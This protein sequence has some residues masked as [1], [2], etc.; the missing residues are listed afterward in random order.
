MSLP[1][2]IDDPA[3]HL[4]E[5]YGGDPANLDV[6][7]MR[8]LVTEAD[9]LA[10]AL[11]YL[12]HH[13]S[14]EQTGNAVTL[15]AVH[16][17]WARQARDLITRRAFRRAYVAPRELGK[18]TWHF[19]AVP[20]WAAAH[21][22]ATFVA[23][24]ADAGRLA[25]THL[26]TFLTELR[27]NERLRQDYPDLCTPL[28]LRRGITEADRVDLYRAKS[29]FIFAARGMEAQA[30]GLK[31]GNHRPDLLILDDIE[32]AEEV[33]SAATVA[34]R[35]ATLQDTVL[36]L[37]DKA[38]VTWVGTVTRAES[39]LHQLVR[40]ARGQMR[41]DD[42]RAAWIGTDRW[43]PHYYPPVV[44]HDDG[45]RESIWP[46][47]WAL[48][49]LDRIAHT[50]SYAKNY[51]NDPVG[52]DGDYWTLA[53]FRR[54]GL[55]GVTRTLLSVDPAVTTKDSSD[56]TG[57]AV[58]EWSPSAGRSGKGRCRVKRAIRVRLGGADL[59]RRILALLEEDPAI[60]LVLIEVNQG[61][62]VWRD[63][64]HDLPVPLKTKHQTVKKE[65]RA[66]AVLNDYQLGDVLHAHG[67]TDLETEQ[68]GFP[69]APHDDL[70]DAAGSGVAY[71]LHRAKAKATPVGA[72]TLSY[73]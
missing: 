24:F 40:V 20:L 65:I 22:H 23:A 66:A 42:E 30:L 57:L 51:A 4:L 69:R 15:S 29:G 27:T 39:N 9:P 33:Y 14:S 32:P 68:A 58:V 49:E 72:R 73:V 54:G 38:R 12:W 26:A 60:G 19:L 61:G 41:P 2:T 21:G 31:I 52:A 3:L 25:E 59:R 6:P 16:V 45:S 47:R 64:L 43:S 48:P 63:I 50:R 71:F 55:D 34:K 35:L 44:E 8:R 70:V 10:F 5:L 67:L 37:N 56:Y 13:L 46:A 17:D 28:T 7:A 1:P 36:P 18:T 62:E 11:T 53:D